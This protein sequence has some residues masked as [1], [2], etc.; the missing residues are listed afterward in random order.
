MVDWTFLAE[1]KFFFGSELMCTQQLNGRMELFSP[2]FY[3]II[4]TFSMDGSK[5]GKINIDRNMDTYIQG[6]KNR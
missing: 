5:S 3:G 6:E 4:F 1:T 2:I